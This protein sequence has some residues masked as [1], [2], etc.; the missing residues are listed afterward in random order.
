MVYAV[1]PFI[2]LWFIVI[3]LRRGDG[4]LLFDIPSDRAWIPGS[5]MKVPELKTKVRQLSKYVTESK[6]YQ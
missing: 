2:Q 5:N 4:L 1:K 3:K 6:L